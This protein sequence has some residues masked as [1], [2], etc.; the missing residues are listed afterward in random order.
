MTAV[1]ALVMLARCRNAYY[2]ALHNVWVKFVLGLIK[3]SMLFVL[4]VY[5]AVEGAD[6]YAPMHI[7]LADMIWVYSVTFYYLDKFVRFLWPAAKA[8][9]ERYK[10]AVWFECWLTL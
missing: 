7:V 1:H 4:T 3:H 10:Y 6:P 8:W 9:I 5:F 2:A